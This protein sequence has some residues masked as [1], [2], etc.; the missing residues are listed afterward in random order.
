M[1]ELSQSPEYLSFRENVPL[2][3]ISVDS[4]NNH[5][6]CVLLGCQYFT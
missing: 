4:M 6:S 3:Q 1:S 5:V 2:K